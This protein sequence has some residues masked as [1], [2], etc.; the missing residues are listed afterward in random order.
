MKRMTVGSCP[1]TG[2]RRSQ[3][4]TIPASAVAYTTR[5]PEIFQ[6]R[7]SQALDSSMTLQVKTKYVL[8]PQLERGC[9]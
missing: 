2:Q 7:R 8:L 5:C 1:A 9:C 6:S 4:V 3:E